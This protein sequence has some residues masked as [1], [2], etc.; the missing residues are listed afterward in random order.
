MVVPTDAVLIA[1]GFHVPV[2]L[3]LDVNGNDGAELFWQSGP[4]C[5]KVGV[6]EVVT[7]ISIVVPAAH[8]PDAGVKVYVVVPTDAVLIAEGFHVPVILLLDV[9]GND[10]AALFWHSGPIA[11]KVGAI[12][13]VTAI[14]IVVI[15]AH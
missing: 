1:E 14:S 3:L 5:V 2:I 7:T 12:E 13:E 6:T 4:T 10:G 15:A 11:V 9:N 8:W